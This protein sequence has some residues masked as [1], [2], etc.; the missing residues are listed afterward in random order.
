MKFCVNI[1]LITPYDKTLVFRA[2]CGKPANLL[3]G[4]IHLST[5]DRMW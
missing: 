3:G 1:C 5:I 4:E 2:D